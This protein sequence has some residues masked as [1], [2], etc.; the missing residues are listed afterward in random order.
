M[1]ID[2]I[3]AA[4]LLSAW[5]RDIPLGRVLT[6]GR[7]HLSLSV[8][9]ITSLE[10]QFS[11]NLQEF[12]GTEGEE[13]F[14]E[15]FLDFL[16]ATAVD[17]IDFSDYE[18]SSLCHDLNQPIPPEWKGKYDFVI[19]GG[20]LEHVFNFPCAIRN[21]MELVAP[22]GCFFGCNP[23]DNWLGHGFYQF[24]PELFFRV[25]TPENG[26]EMID[27]LLTEDVADGS[28]Y[29]VIDPA[30]AGHRINLRSRE[31]VTLVVLAKKT[32][33]VPELFK[34]TPQQSD[35]ICRWK[36]DEEETRRGSGGPARLRAMMKR[37][38]PGRLV[39]QIQKRAIV[40][41]HAIEG[42]RS[43]TKLRSMNEL[44]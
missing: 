28:V 19:D 33:I 1:A 6:L 44:E 34:E 15:P 3:G 31:R 22:G 8:E 43:V 42:A 12:V 9:M 16:G 26:F 40:R 2:Y 35:Y 32:C 18:G 36:T 27:L 39:R 14:A 10:R 29:K 5:R 24:G 17:S 30:I 23:A 11:V 25:F 38:L 4:L 20:T 37:V 13:R 21:A 7:Q 41:R